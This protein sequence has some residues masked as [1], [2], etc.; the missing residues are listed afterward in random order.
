MSEKMN[1]MQVFEQ[2]VKLQSSLES[3]DNILFKI[4][5]VTD[6]QEYDKDDEGNIIVLDYMPEVSL[7]KIKAIRE[8]AMSRETTVRTLLDFYLSVYKK[9]EEEEASAQ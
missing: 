8:I 7:E 2:I 9:L 1:K 5:V 3:I 4:Q 6:S